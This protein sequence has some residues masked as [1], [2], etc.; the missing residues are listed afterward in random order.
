MRVFLRTMLALLAT[1]SCKTVDITKSPA[2]RAKVSAKASVADATA[3]K[4]LVTGVKDVS[5]ADMPRLTVEVD[6]TSCVGVGKWIDPKTPAS[7]KVGAVSVTP[8]LENVPNATQPLP[9][10]FE[11]VV[12]TETTKTVHGTGQ[13]SWRL[14]N[15]SYSVQVI[16]YDVQ[17]TAL[18]SQISKSFDFKSSNDLTLKVVGTWK[19]D[20][21]CNLQWQ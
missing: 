16:A 12:D 13:Y 11:P 7:P 17:T 5:F 2:P 14:T 18:E 3:K 19:P 21:T 6:V 20:M 15:G 1:Q 8:R 4:T 10:N 9:W